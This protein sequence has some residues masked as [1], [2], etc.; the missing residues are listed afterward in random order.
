MIFCEILIIDDDP[1]DVEILSEA[2]TESGVTCVHHVNSAVKAFLY[3]A[4]LELEHLPKLIVTDL[5]LPG[6]TGD[7]FLRDLKGREV[8]KHIHVVILSSEK[9]EKEIERYR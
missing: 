6:I 9:T 3:L 2:F 4:G 8:Y 5:Y 1:E 7:E